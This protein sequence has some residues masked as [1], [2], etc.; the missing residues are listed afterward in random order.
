MGDLFG[1]SGGI[2]TRGLLVPNQA[3]YQASP[4]P[5]SLNIIM[6]PSW[7]VKYESMFF[8][9]AHR[10][11]AGVTKMNQKG[12][13]GS[14]SWLLVGLAAL[15]LAITVKTCC[16]QANGFFQDLIATAKDSKAA[17]AFY[18]FSSSLKEDGRIAEAFSRSYTILRNEAN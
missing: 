18:A 5:V 3:R 4:R 17:Q 16:P 10:M 14:G 7:N 2:R 9:S 8:P 15:V 6:N 13:R 11:I 12:K 1:R